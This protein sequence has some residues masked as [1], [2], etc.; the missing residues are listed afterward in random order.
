MKEWYNITLVQETKMSKNP[1]NAVQT[2]EQPK[3]KVEQFAGQYDVLLRQHKTA[4]GVFR[5]LKAEGLTTGE[6]AKV[7]GKRYQHVRNVLITPLTSKSPS[8]AP[9]TNATNK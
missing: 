7:T 3:S 9:A 8:T 6:I 1:T 5:Y 2:A 4:S